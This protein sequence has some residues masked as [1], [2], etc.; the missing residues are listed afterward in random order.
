MDITLRGLGKSFGQFEVFSGIDL[1]IP[2][3]TYACLLGPSGCG[4]STLMRIVAGLEPAS[5]GDIL[6]AGERVNDRSS[7]ER[8]VGL[9]FQNYALYPHLNVADNLR[10]PLRAPARR[11]LYPDKLVEN[12]I[13]E[14]AELL[15]IGHLLGRSVNQLSGG[16]QQRVALGRALVRRPKVLLLDEPVTHLDARLRHEMRVELKELHR[17]MG[18]TTIHVTHDQQEALAMA[19]TMILMK[20]GRIEQV[21]TPMDLY[22]RPSSAFVAGFIGDPP[23]TL[24]TGTVGFDGGRPVLDLGDARLPLPERLIRAHAGLEGRKVRIALPIEATT[25]GTGLSARVL[26][27]EMVQN[28]QRIVFDLGGQRVNFQTLSP[29]EARNGESRSLVLDTAGLDVFDAETGAFL[30]STQ[31]KATTEP[32]GELA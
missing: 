18:T 7:L 4:K 29:V 5:A 24:L 27:H 23:R 8:D 16:Q 32:Q 1:H 12:R 25:L 9:A 15:R 20:G 22:H 3:G 21:G 26:A 17:L 28:R 19:D 31:R 10:F 14:I 11:H 30:A 6:F 2:T 13:G